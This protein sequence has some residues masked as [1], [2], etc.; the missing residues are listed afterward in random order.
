MVAVADH[1][2]F[3]QLA[4]LA[5]VLLGA[6]G[7]TVLV[8]PGSDALSALR[9]VGFAHIDAAVVSADAE[10]EAAAFARSVGGK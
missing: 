6:R 2:A 8:R 1:A 9:S 10:P 5:A 7:R 3:R 4:G